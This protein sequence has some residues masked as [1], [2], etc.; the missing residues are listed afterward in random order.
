[1]LRISCPP[2][3]SQVQ[4]QVGRSD[5]LYSTIQALIIFQHVDP[6]TLT[7]RIGIGDRSVSR[8][9]AQCAYMRAD[10]RGESDR[11]GG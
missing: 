8:S 10:D 4:T 5:T 7:V 1:L 2:A 9:D 3:A 6:L 11:R